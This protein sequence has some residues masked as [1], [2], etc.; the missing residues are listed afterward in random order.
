MIT[1][2]ADERVLCA[3]HRHWIVVAQKMTMVVFLLLGAL[4]FFLLLPSFS[5]GPSL[6]PFIFY[7]FL[8]YLLIVL[9][10]AFVLWMDYYLDVWIVTTERVIDVEQIGMFRRE[11]SEFPLSNIQDVT[12]EIP[13]FIATLLHYGTIRIQTAGNQSFVAHEIPDVDRVKNIILEEA[14]KHRT[15][16]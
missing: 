13:G 2:H 7:L 15:L 1:L 10:V 9:L 4:I 14:R 6:L 12:V 16:K 11:A 5:I 3:V 8:I